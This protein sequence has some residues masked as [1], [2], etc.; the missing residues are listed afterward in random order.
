MKERLLVFVKYY[1][2]WLLFFLIQ[3]PIFM[4][5]QM[6]RMGELSFTDW[7]AVPWHALPL[8]LSVASYVMLLCGILIAA[9]SLL[10][11]CYFRRIMEVY[12]GILLTVGLLTFIGDI[13]VFPAWGFHLDK[14]IFIYLSSPKEVL[15][16][17]D[18]WVWV[19][20]LIVL[21]GSWLACFYAYRYWM[22]KIQMPQL[23]GWK[24]K[25]G[26]ALLFILLTALLFLPIRGSVTTSTMNTGR[27]YFSNNQM[28]N[29]AAVNPL[30]NIV[31]S[32]G[33]NTFDTKKYTYMPTEEAKQVVGSLFSP[34]DYR[35]S[36]GLQYDLKTKR[37][38]I[39]LFILE[40]FSS[41]AWEAMPN[42]QKLSTEGIYFSNVMASSF[43]T[44][45]GVVAIMSAFPGQPTSSI[46]TVPYKS[47]GLP[48]LGKSLSK[49]GYQLKFWYGGD[50]DF[51]N[52]RSYLISGG[53]QDRVNDHSFS[54]DERLSKWGVHDH[55]LFHRAEQEIASRFSRGCAE[56]AQRLPSLDVILSLSSHEP[57]EMQSS[58]D[59][60]NKYLN[61]IAYTDSC[62][63]AFVD[64][65]RLSEMWD[66]TLL[67]F[68]AD[69]G[70]PYPFELQNH[71][72]LRYHIPIIFAGGAVK[73]PK[74]VDYVC[75]QNDLV[76]T[77]LAMM[78]IDHSEYTFA[79]NA[80]DTTIAPFAFYS[81][82]DGFALIT[83][84]DTIAIDA[85]SGK[86]LM[87]NNDDLEHKARAFVQRV[88]ETID[89]L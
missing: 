47:K 24:S 12:T 1:L 3:K 38:N 18:W 5:S 55:V 85:K 61:S 89:E 52:M 76:P 49:E 53:F 39:I 45:R 43:R 51:T 15:A 50:E 11:V 70:Y 62:I 83:D 14:T 29:L 80:L 19:L 30:F 40:S 21:I 63:G 17:A 57:F 44:D 10:Y 73:E 69:H 60:G 67:V 2:F 42:L 32:L 20:G 71:E 9:T 54:V 72:P 22:G 37:P 82:V 33:E 88:M 13:G 35:T 36:V 23:Q 4:L 75:S 84:N 6:P 31:E 25:T 58:H 74:R 66:S 68:V 87:G 81:F 86:R 16:C 8:D 7:L 64:T 26:N 48:Q 65:L 78:D 34:S 28:L 77:M 27:V 79:K 46:M 56:V 59:Y 41:N